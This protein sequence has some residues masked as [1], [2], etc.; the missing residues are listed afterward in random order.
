MACGWLSYWT[1]QQSHEA[2]K[3]LW[4][5]GEDIKNNSKILYKF[6]LKSSLPEI[7]LIAFVVKYI[8][9]WMPCLCDPSQFTQNTKTSDSPSEGLEY[10]LTS[11][12]HCGD[13]KLMDLM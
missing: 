1:A 13:D 8:W 10:L 7:V 6:I 3:S 9:T 2:F 4:E 12:R 5:S 11:Q